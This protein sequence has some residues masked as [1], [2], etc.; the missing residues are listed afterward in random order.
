M[1]RLRVDS[2]LMKKYAGWLVAGETAIILQAPPASLEIALNLL[3]GAG[4]AQ[5]AI[6][7]FHPARE[8]DKASKPDNVEYMTAVQLSGQA[9]LLAGYQRVHAY[10]GHKPPLLDQVDTHIEEIDLCRRELEESI[11]LEQRIT[12]SAEW[13]LDN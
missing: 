4:E 13:I 2:E 12:P 9:R 11:R 3:R 6:F 8:S 5:P 10:T 1:S 7:A